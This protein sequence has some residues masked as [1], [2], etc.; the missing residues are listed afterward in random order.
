MYGM[1][2]KIT[3]VPEQRE[4]LIAILLEGTNAMPGCLSYIIA[5]DTTDAN[6]IWVTEVWESEQSHRASL[7]LPSVQ[8][9]IAKGK[10][11]ISGF[12]E[13]FVTEPV[14]GQGLRH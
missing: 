14:G 11:L 1:I 10:P 13:R 4:S 2:G 9:A 8:Q 3:T 12:G 7:S 6:A 5:K